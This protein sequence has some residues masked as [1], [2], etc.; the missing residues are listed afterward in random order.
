MESLL[1]KD[2]QVEKRGPQTATKRR[3]RNIISCMNSDNCMRTNHD[4]ASECNDVDDG[5]M[6]GMGQP[7]LKPS[8]QKEFVLWWKK[9]Q[10]KK[11]KEL[12]QY[13][14]RGNRICKVH[15]LGWRE[16]QQ[17]I[18]AVC[19]KTGGW[20]VAHHEGHKQNQSRE[21]RWT[22]DNRQGLL[23]FFRQAWGR[24]GWR[25]TRIKY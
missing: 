8:P 19:W 2:R 24:E 7:K 12:I 17:R 22:Q 25:K 3:G 9:T 11:T 23:E 16:K 15:S 14:V 6:M 18:R 1:A 21:S 10:Y 13:W 20:G 4:W 5:V